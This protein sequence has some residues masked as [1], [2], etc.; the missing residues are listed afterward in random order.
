[1]MAARAIKVDENMKVC[2]ADGKRIRNVNGYVETT[3][4]K[5]LKGPFRLTVPAGEPV[6]LH[7]RCFTE[8]TGQPTRHN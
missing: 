1:M 5:P 4:D 2:D 7:K 6:V 8:L 3:L